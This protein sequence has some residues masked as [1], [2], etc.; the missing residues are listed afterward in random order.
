[1]KYFQ[2]FFS[3]FILH[4]SF[5][6]LFCLPSVAQKIDK[7]KFIFEDQ[8]KTQYDWKAISKQLTEGRTSKLEQAE[9]L[10]NFVCEQLS[11]DVEGKLFHVDECWDKKRGVCQGYC[12]LYYC[13]AKAAGL[14]CHII[15]GEAKVRDNVFE[16]HGWVTVRGDSEWILMDPTWGSGSVNEGKF[17]RAKDYS[18]WFNVSPEWMIFKHFPDKA[19][20][21]MLKPT[22]S[23]EVFNRLPCCSPLDEFGLDGKALLKDA[24]N[25]KVTTLPI[26]MNDGRGVV[27]LKDFPLK[28]SLKAGQPYTF[29]LKKQ[30][31]MEVCLSHEDE[32]VEE[33][34]WQMESNGNI[35]VNYIPFKEG[36]LTLWTM[37][38]DGK[39]HG[40]VQY[41]VEAPDREGQARIEKECPWN[42]PEVAAVKN[43]K[44]EFFTRI[45]GLDAAKVV[46]EAKAGKL[47][48]VPVFY[49]ASENQSFVLHEMPLTERLKVG[50]PYFFNITPISSEARWAIQNG[51]NWQN[52]WET[53]DDGSQRMMV[54]PQ[55][56]GTLN[57]LVEHA[58]VGTGFY[59]ILQY[60]VE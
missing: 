48:S 17:F 53:L 18:I 11:Y 40:I 37:G 21:Q 32:W 3:F 8:I 44:K 50:T 9:A 60:I 31:D 2:P 16:A 33:K 22:V 46:R 4:A 6:I 19:N 25:K 56:T 24:V 1:M 13:L 12:E 49:P 58:S 23:R 35:T 55:E 7:S 29:S 38:K 47:K 45:P 39:Y 10:Y 27:H 20:M 5:F 14:E 28:K 30:T 59:V 54:T 26:F 41:D 52:A 15:S 57:L 43:M 42:V 51:S 36:T 34:D